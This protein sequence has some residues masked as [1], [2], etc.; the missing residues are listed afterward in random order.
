MRGLLCHLSGKKDDDSLREIRFEEAGLAPIHRA[1][2]GAWNYNLI[3]TAPLS[4]KDTPEVV[5]EQL[6]YQFN[7]EHPRDYHSP[8][9][10]VSDIVAIRRT[11]RYPVITATALVFSRSPV[12]L[13]RTR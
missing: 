10:S 2:G 4:G 8:S 6:F 12:F 13:T 5:A 9:M 3:Y 11:A 1:R 7:N